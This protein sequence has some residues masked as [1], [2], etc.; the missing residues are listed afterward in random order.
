M[1]QIYLTPSVPIKTIRPLTSIHILDFIGYWHGDPSAITCCSCGANPFLVM[2]GDTYLTG[3]VHGTCFN[4]ND[5]DFPVEF[6]MNHFWEYRVDLILLFVAWWLVC[7][8]CPNRWQS[9]PMG[10]YHDQVLPILATSNFINCYNHSE[11]TI[12]SSPRITA[13]FITSSHV[14]SSH[15]NLQ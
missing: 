9:P 2:L 6:P 10:E 1:G 14:L 5:R 8:T 13:I 12:G 4:T 7:S 3:L 15:I 11:P